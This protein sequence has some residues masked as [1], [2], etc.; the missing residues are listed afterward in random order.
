MPGRSGTPT[1]VIL[2]LVAVERDARDD[3]CFHL[4]VFLESDQRALA[5]VLEAG[6]HAQSDPVL[7]GELDRPDLQHLRAEARH[8]EHFLEGDGLE[9]PCVRLDARIGGVDTVDVGVDVALVGLERRGDRHGGSVR[10][11]A[12]Q[13]RD[14]AVFV[15][16]LETGDH[17]HVVV[18]QIGPYAGPRRC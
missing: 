12:T 18:S 8:L 13:G 7:A 14:V 2:R 4:F 1:T 10:S 16:A 11:A 6:E 3:G 9:P 15:L 17:H 5:F